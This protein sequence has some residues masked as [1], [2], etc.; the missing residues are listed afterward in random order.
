M[1]GIPYL[2]EVWNVCSG[3]GNIA[4]PTRSTCWARDMVR[5]FP[6][7]HGYMEK[8]RNTTE[9]TPWPFEQVQFHPERLFKPLHWRKPRRIGLCYMG[10]LFDEQVPFEWIDNIFAV[11]SIAG[12]HQ[13]FILTKQIN[14][15]KEYTVELLSG[16]RKI[17]SKAT[18]IQNSIV[19][20]LTVK[21]QHDQGWPSIFW[22]V[23]IT[24]Q[25]DADRMIPELLTIPGKH[26]VSYEP[27]LGPVDFGQYL[28]EQAGGPGTGYDYDVVTRKSFKWLVIGSHNNPK[29]YPCKL[30]WIQTAVAQARQANVPCF[31]KQAD[32]GIKLVKMPEILG[33]V[34]DEYP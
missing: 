23:T 22:G 32:F 16:H 6:R 8:N 29:K 20:G 4:C 15:I 3:C 33:R 14:R 10:D 13:F 21:L 26:W 27:A 12:H 34:W 25:K 1:T 30:D 9:V 18:E 24:C 28:W 17:C 11:M 2:D 19:G 31:V 5:R 7:I